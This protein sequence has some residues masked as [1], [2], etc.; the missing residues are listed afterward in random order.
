MAIKSN[1]SYLTL[2]K[3]RKYYL[4]KCYLRKDSLPSLLKFTR[5]GWDFIP[6]MVHTEFICAVVLQ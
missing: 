1:I 4:R 5:N 2:L 6:C 3:L